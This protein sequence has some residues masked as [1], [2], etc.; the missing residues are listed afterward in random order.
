MILGCI[1]SLQE[2]IDHEMCLWVPFWNLYTY[3]FVG[4]LTGRACL[5]LM[6]RK[7]VRMALVRKTMRMEYWKQWWKTGKN[8]TRNLRRHR[9]FQECRWGP[10]YELAGG[11]KVKTFEHLENLLSERYNKLRRKRNSGC[12]IK[13]LDDNDCWITFEWKDRII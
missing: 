8:K 7:T 11:A 1:H 2:Y 5:S 13:D 9:G 10:R 3:K 4:M 6:E 12:W